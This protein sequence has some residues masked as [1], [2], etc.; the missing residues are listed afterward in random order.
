[1]VTSLSECLKLTGLF[2]RSYLRTSDEGRERKGNETDPHVIF[3]KVT[4]HCIVSFLILS[5]DE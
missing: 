5:K 4:S 3:Y 1:M 2:L